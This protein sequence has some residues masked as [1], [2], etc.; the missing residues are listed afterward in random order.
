[1]AVLSSSNLSA[2]GFLLVAMLHTSDAFTTAPRVSRT[3]SNQRFAP[4][5]VPRAP[6]VV[7]AEEGEP[8]TEEEKKEAV[9]N[10]VENDEWEGLTMELSE[11]IKTAVVEDIK[12]KT[13]DFIGKDNYQVG[14]ITKEIDNKVKKEIATM[15]GKE[16]YELG[17][18]VVVMDQYVS[19]TSIFFYFLAYLFQTH[20]SNTF[21]SKRLKT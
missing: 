16:E 9:G 2:L 17:D 7:Y 1:M 13:K 5:T 19:F 3:L 15:R 14:D 18:L 8:Q 12:K 4:T 20:Y 11:V 21:S 6:V 10:L